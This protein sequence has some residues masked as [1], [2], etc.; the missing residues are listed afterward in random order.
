MIKS[1]FKVGI[2]SLLVLSA[3]FATAIS[4]HREKEWAFLIFLNGNNNLAEFGDLN[5]NQLETIG[6]TDQV[7]VIVQWAKTGVDNTYRLRVEKDAD[8]KKV[9]SPFIETLPR[10]DMG[11]Y[12]KLVEF[13]KWS[14]EHY[15]A[16]HYFV[17][18]WNHGSGWTRRSGQITKGVSY[19]DYSGNHITTEQMGI[20]MR[21][22][23]QIIGHNVDLV[24]ADACLMQMGEVASQMQDSVDY[25]VASEELEPGLGWPYHTFLDRWV[26]NPQANGGE[27]GTFLVEEYFTYLGATDNIT[28]STMNLNR[29]P[30]LWASFRKLNSMLVNQ[31]DDTLRKLMAATSGA[32][33]FPNADAIDL[34]HWLKKGS[35]AR[36]IDAQTIEDVHTALKNVIISNKTAAIFKDAEGL[37]FWVPT[38]KSGLDAYAQ[39]YAQLVWTQET[40]WDQVLGKLLTLPVCVLAPNGQWASEVVAVSSEYGTGQDQWAASQVLGA[41]NTGRYGDNGTAWAPKEMNNPEESITVGFA[42]AVHADGAIV[43]ETL[44]TGFVTKIEAIDDAGTIHVVWQGEDVATNGTISDF[45]ANWERTEYLVKALKISLNTAKNSSWE[46]IDSITLLGTP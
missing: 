29:L 32:Q 31:N 40:G 19:D 11:D 42:T 12:K 41:C 37:S 18:F 26:K 25:Y 17:S 30:E 23:K 33:G 21:E 34:G 4:E 8:D 20:A 38:T 16:K 2:V 45:T 7:D 36:L 22:I 27:V 14:H 5:I 13:V 39:R 43:R 1:L 3:G 46:E 15:P 10:V 28:L 9:T 35:E 6:S 44:D 24:G